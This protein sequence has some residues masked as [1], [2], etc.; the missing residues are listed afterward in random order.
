MKPLSLSDKNQ[1]IAAYSRA[2]RAITTFLTR[3][4]V[5]LVSLGVDGHIVSRGVANL[6]DA[7]KEL[8]GIAIMMEDWVEHMTTSQ[9]NAQANPV[10]SGGKIEDTAALPCTPPRSNCLGQSPYL[11]PTPAAPNPAAPYRVS[12]PWSAFPQS[13]SQVRSLSRRE[14]QNTPLSIRDAPTLFNHMRAV[15]TY[16]TPPRTLDL[17]GSPMISRIT[18]PLAY[19]GQRSSID[20][21]RTIP[22]FFWRPAPKAHAV[23]LMVPDS[24]RHRK[25]PG[26]DNE[27]EVSIASAVGRSTPSLFM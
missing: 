13:S 22:P 24:A 27:E 17:F 25:K 19:G 5:F 16:Q 15:P 10:E 23:K 1:L 4:G 3:A 11:G 26:K 9:K 18:T 12:T 21:P 20:T 2:L 7:L 6:A 8:Q 14:I